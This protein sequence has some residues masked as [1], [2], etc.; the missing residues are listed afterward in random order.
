M[1]CANLLWS[2]LVALFP[3]QTDTLDLTYHA[4]F[5]DHGL[6]ETDLGVTVGQLAA[7]GI[8]TLRANDSRFPSNPPPFT[9][10]TDL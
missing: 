10:G 3:A 7:A 5:T 4:Y 1:P 8:L 6:S 2:D 9:G